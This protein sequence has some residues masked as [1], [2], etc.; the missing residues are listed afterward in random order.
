MLLNGKE[1]KFLI[2]AL[3]DPRDNEMGLW[4]Q[5][6]S[7][8]LHGKQKNTKGYTFKYTNNQCY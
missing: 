7:L 6:I 1:S 4:R 5:G 3:V 2:Y 8:V